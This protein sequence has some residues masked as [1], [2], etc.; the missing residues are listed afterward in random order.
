VSEPEEHVLAVPT[1]HLWQVVPPFQGFRPFDG[2]GLAALLNPAHL[3]FLPRAAAEADETHKQLIPY[4]VLTC[5]GR[6]FHYTRGGSGTEAR[7]RARRSVGVGG[8]VNPVD[9]PIAD[10]YHA[11]L[12]RELSEEVELL[13]P[14]TE[15]LLGLINDDS[16]AVGRVHVGIVHLVELAEPA[17]RSREEGL[18]DVGFA[19]P[20]ELLADATAFESWS[21][22]VLERLGS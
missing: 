10:A 3:V 4:A 2:A 5:G 12:L 22:L 21:R 1:S 17:V 9:G 11:G 7:L 18:T 15:R 8:H 19:T 20:A 13:A 14:H 6:V 16:V